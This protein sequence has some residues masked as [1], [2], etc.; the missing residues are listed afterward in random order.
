ML[1]Y[2][3]SASCSCSNAN[4]NPGDPNFNHFSCSDG[5]SAYCS[6]NVR[7]YSNTPFPRSNTA[8]GCASGGCS[9]SCAI[10]IFGACIIY[11]AY[12]CPSWNAGCPN[13]GWWNNQ[14]TCTGGTSVTGTEQCT[15]NGMEKC[16][17]CSAGYYM[18]GNTCN[19]NLCTCSGGTGS[20]ELTCPVDG[21]EHCATCYPGYDGPD[22]VSNT[23]SFRQCTCEGG[24]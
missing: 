15:S 12:E 16:S 24:M 2:A 10:Q 18:S 1:W 9:R 7:C 19:M 14:C 17:S 13:H 21:Q 6:Y 23:C 20:T 22:P 5:F 8:C 4:S 3:N 11:N